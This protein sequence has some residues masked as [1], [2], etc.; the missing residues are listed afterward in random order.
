LLF[1]KHTKQNATTASVLAAAAWFMQFS[2]GRSTSVDITAK[3]K[4]NK[5]STPQVIKLSS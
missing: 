4:V 2:S 1:V 3:L 5:K